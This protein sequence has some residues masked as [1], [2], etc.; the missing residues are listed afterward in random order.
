MSS[1]NEWVLDESTLPERVVDDLRRYLLRRSLPIIDHGQRPFHGGTIHSGRAVLRRLDCQIDV[2]LA[3]DKS[4]LVLCAK[5]NQPE[6]FWTFGECFPEIP[7]HA[8][9]NDFFFGNPPPEFKEPLLSKVGLADSVWV[10]ISAA[11]EKRIQT[12][13]LEILETFETMRGRTQDTKLVAGLNM[14]GSPS[15]GGSDHLRADALLKTVLP[16]NWNRAVHQA[17]VEYRAGAP[18]LS[19]PIP[20]VHREVSLGPCKLTDLTVTLSAR[21]Y[22]VRRTPDLRLK[23]ALELDSEKFTFTADYPV[24]GDIVEAR[25][26]VETGKPLPFIGK[27]V[28]LPDFTTPDMELAV[29]VSL[30]KRENAL[31]KAQLDLKLQRTWVVV[32]DVLEIVNPEFHFL[33]LDPVA[34]TRR[35][36]ARVVGELRIDGSM[37][38]VSGNYAASQGYSEGQFTVSLDPG[39]PLSL[40]KL[41]QHLLRTDADA[42]LLALPEYRLDALLFEYDLNGHIFMETSV[43]VPW[44]LEFTSD[45]CLVFEQLRF[46]FEKWGES[47]RFRAGADLE[48]GGLRFSL[49]GDYSSANGWL[50]QGATS[51]GDSIHIG[52]FVR[53]LGIVEDP[54]ASLADLLL[55]DVAFTFHTKSKNFEFTIKTAFPLGETALDAVVTIVN[56]DDTLQFGGKITVGRAEFTLD[57]TTDPREK[58]LVA[59]WKSGESQPLDLST[60]SDDL[61]DV[62]DLQS[63]LIPASASLKL[64]LNDGKKSL[65]IDGTHRSGAKVA[66]LL[67]QDSDAA[68]PRWMA[69]LG[70]QPGKI[71]TASL[72]PLGSALQPHNIA[73]D[74]LVVVA[75]SADAPKGVQLTLDSQPYAVSTGLSLQG[76]LEFE[77]TSFSFP[78]EC[79]LGGEE[80]KKARPPGGTPNTM[81]ASPAPTVNSLDETTSDQIP[82]PEEGKNN[83]VVGRTIGPVTFRKARLES[84]N[85]RIHVMLDASLSS[86]NFTLDLTG[87]NVNFPWTLLQDPLE[88]AGDIRVGLDGLS[89]SYSDPP[90]TISGT[91]A[92]TAVVPPY[93]D[94]L[95]RGHLLIKAETFQITVLG[96]YGSILTNG[97]KTPALFLY[98]TYA[99]VLGGPP[100]FF[101]L[102]LALGGGYNTRLTLPPIENVAEF[103]LVE[104]VTDPEKFA[105]GG[106]TRLQEAVQPSYG[107]HWLAVGVKFTSFKMADSFALFSVSFGNRLQFAMLGLTKL[108][109]PAG[110]DK[111]QCAAYAELAI[112]AVVDPQA[113]VFSIEGR[114]TQN[115]HIL[116]KEFRLTGGF[117]YFVW[118]GKAAEAGDFVISLGGYHPEFLRPPHYPDVPRVGIRGKIG[119]L[120]VTGEAYLALT[121]SCLMAGEKLEAVFEASRIRAAFV[122]YVDFV[123]AWAP[124]HYD[125]RIAIGIFVTV[126][127]LRTFKLEAHASLHVWGPPF[128]GTARVSVWIASFTIAFG[129]PR[130]TQPPPLSWDDF[131]NAFL[132]AP[133]SNAGGLSTIRITDGMVREVKKKEKQG[134]QE[135]EVIYRIVNPHELTIETDSVVPC[136]EVCVGAIRTMGTAKLGIRPM[137]E[138]LLESCHVVS[139]SK[140]DESRVEGQFHPIHWSKR[141]YPEALWS[142]NAASRKP[143]AGMVKDVPSGVVLRVQPVIPEHPLGPF[144]IEKFKYESI[145]KRIP[146]SAAASPIEPE[147]AEFSGVSAENPLR[148]HIRDCLAK[149]VSKLGKSSWNEIVMTN[150]SSKPSEYFQAWPTRAALG[151]TDKNS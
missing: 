110:A 54:P 82:A 6:N 18:V 122:A 62:S 73:L 90:L 75:A 40:T 129:D 144:L 132:P 88:R 112:R 44:R 137:R 151:Q 135:A 65:A 108:T 72:G 124:F 59:T 57:F 125:A 121:P 97:K 27:P 68:P 35:I 111:D 20:L 64:N 115:S 86:G 43:S 8:S 33:V 19:L 103:P 45:L 12:R 78:F 85:K 23:A 98:G 48:L 2:Y 26:E 94:D 30:S 92:R 69:A 130:G 74:K 42:D 101:V 107:D 139:I 4:L 31:K 71:S 81:S 28:G 116:A 140:N 143:E 91:F 95:Y 22:Y 128:A 41:V 14:F 76:A 100:A 118:F 5:P 60:I 37:L 47:T 133:D 50:F 136:S 9:V 147:D 29:G 36:V 93:V 89:I 16:E 38:L 49:S 131:R 70:L 11:D 52:A 10:L 109:L 149:H 61:P 34:D 138:T 87:L 142:A 3:D 39:M 134:E 84:R 79:R 58:E 17:N 141:N 63:L 15:F 83:V 21:M 114:L 13:A 67:A 120:A 53:K 126:R 7:N 102:G 32:K 66:F 105:K 24:D 51:P 148:D 117:A 55:Q 113:G 56:K 104:A 127:L 99:G 80:R 77:E 150:T 46:V 1:P 106:N 123:I 119:S 25:L 146:W 145:P 96:S